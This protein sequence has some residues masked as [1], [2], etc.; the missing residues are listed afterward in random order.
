MYKSGLYGLFVIL[1]ALAACSSPAPTP[2]NANPAQTATRLVVVPTVAATA[3][4]SPV[5]PATEPAKLVGQPA[6]V[7]SAIAAAIEAL[8]KSGPYRMTIT[9]SND[10][11]G[12]VTLDVIPPDRSWYKASLDGMPVEVINIG[13]TAYVLDPDGTWQISTTTDSSADAQLIDPA[14]ALT[15]VEILPPQTINGTPTTVYSF[16]DFNFARR[17]SNIVGQ[18]G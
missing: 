18:S 4:P 9:A 7:R 12:P 11:G 14:S 5:V 17:Y 15:N 13:N 8:D 2:P 6:D 10:G 1:L 3:A 16:V